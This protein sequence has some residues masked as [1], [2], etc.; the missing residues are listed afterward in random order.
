[1]E[2]SN[3]LPFNHYRSESPREFEQNAVEMHADNQPRTELCMNIDLDEKIYS[4]EHPVEFSAFAC[5]FGIYTNFQM[6]QICLK[7][8]RYVT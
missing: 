8:Q 7:I 6:D 1:M 5:H 2:C 4:I 3:K